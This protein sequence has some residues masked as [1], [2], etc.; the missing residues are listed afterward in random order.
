MLLST[1]A[2]L[3]PFVEK[4]SEELDKECHTSACASF[5]RVCNRIDDIMD[6]RK[7]WRLQSFDKLSQALQQLYATQQQLAH[8]AK[9][10]QFVARRPCM[11]LRPALAQLP[12]GRWEASYSGLR[13]IG[14]TPDEAMDAFDAI[15]VGQQQ[16]LEE[17]LQQQQSPQKKSRKKS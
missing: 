4:A 6:D 5:I 14:G 12:D 10:T 13:A 15:Y 1:T 9:V 2:V 7:R 17:H 3:R 11:L 16:L 8:E